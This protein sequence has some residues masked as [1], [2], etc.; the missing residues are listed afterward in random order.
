MLG[1]N[2]KINEFLKDIENE[3][4]IYEI[5]QKETTKPLQKVVSFVAFSRFAKKSIKRKN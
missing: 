3:R 4:A 5:L 2:E 1:F